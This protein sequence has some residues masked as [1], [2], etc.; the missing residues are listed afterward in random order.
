MI[1][2]IINFLHLMATT[3]WIGGAIY[4]HFIL[5]PALKQIDQQQSGKLQGIIA[6]RFSIYQRLQST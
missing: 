6:K 3:V 4:I 1:H 5:F 2:N